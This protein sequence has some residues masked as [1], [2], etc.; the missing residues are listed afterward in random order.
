M[1][2]FKLNQNPSYK[3]CWRIFFMCSFMIMSQTALSADLNQSSI[4]FG[5]FFGRSTS[6]NQGVVQFLPTTGM[7]YSITGIHLHFLTSSDCYSG[8]VGG[9]YFPRSMQKYQTQEDTPVIIRGDTVY[10][11]GLTVVRGA[12]ISAVHSLL[13]RLISD[14]HGNSDP[15]FAYFIGECEDQNI[16]CC[17]PVTCSDQDGQCIAVHEYPIQYLFWR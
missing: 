9:F 14:E 12:P 7:A 15:R 11:A 4:P 1:L 5:D 16:N 3:I 2:H 13:I 17:V 8:Y 10:R 6:D